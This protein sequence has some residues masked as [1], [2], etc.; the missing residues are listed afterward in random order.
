[1][2]RPAFGPGV[3]LKSAVTRTRIATHGHTS[4][5]SSVESGSPIVVS[6]SSHRC[7]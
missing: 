6:R 1:M 5:P 7:H 2:H 4:H 3:W